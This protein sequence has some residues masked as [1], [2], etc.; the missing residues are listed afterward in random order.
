M[1]G[2]GLTGLLDFYDAALEMW[3]PS[4]GPATEA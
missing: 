3:D 4:Y 1:S 2:G